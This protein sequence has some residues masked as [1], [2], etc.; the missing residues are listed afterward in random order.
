MTMLLTV[1]IIAL[2]AFLFGFLLGILSEP[3][4]KP[5]RIEKIN[6]RSDAGEELETL[7]KEYRNFLQY[8]GSEQA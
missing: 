4:E 2:S 7:R 6:S 5:V 8:D 1:L 3:T